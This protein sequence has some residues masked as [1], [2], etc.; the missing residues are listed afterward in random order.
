MHMA[1]ALVSP[2]V[3]VTMYAA[4]AA[5]AG[6]SLVQ[7]HK[8]EAAAPELA[9][10]K[11]PTM[12]VMSALVFA[13]Q[14]INYTI[15]GTGSSGHLCGG[16]LL[17]AILGPW[18]GFL[19]MIVILAI[20]ALFFADGG[21]LALGANVWN[22]A[23]YG[24]FVGYFLIYRPLMQGRLLAGKGRTKLVLASVLGCVVTLQLGALSVVVETSL[25]GITALPFGAFAALMQPIHLAIGLVEGGITAAVL[26]FVYQTRPE[27]L[28]CASASGAKNRCSRRATLA[29]LAAAALV[30]GGGLSLLASSNPDGLE[31]S[32]FGNEE[33]GY[34]ANMGLDEEAYGAE[35]AAAEK[36]AAVQEK[37]S[38]LPDYNFAGSD[39][40]AGTS[41]YA[42]QSTSSVAL[43]RQLPLIGEASGVSGKLHKGRCTAANLQLRISIFFCFSKRKRW[44][45]RNDHGGTSRRKR[46]LL[47]S[48][49]ISSF[50]NRELNSRFGGDFDFP[51]DSLEPTRKTASVFLDFS[52]DS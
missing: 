30:I 2:A 8:E 46:R 6:V 37:T 44:R 25:S 23:F 45:V 17:S 10:K 36:A 29:I 48:V 42:A 27:L 5:A 18:A 19:S 39:S 9:K 21:L 14:M 50:P 7:L 15:P 32:L 24:C 31:W 38:L 34:S 52:R 12:A 13:G 43:R 49:L 26:L 28:Q 47:S 20:Q 4:S 51:S 40:A 22:M 16:M 3:A 11:L 1:D 35:S 41:V 33:A